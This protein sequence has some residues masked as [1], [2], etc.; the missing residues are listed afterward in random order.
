MIKKSHVLVFLFAFAIS[1]CATP[2]FGDAAI[3]ESAIFATKTKTTKS[4]FKR[5]LSKCR[6]VSNRLTQSRGVPQIRDVKTIESDDPADFLGSPIY[7]ENRIN[8]LRSI[9]NKK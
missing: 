1:M 3:L 9:L 8:R 5:S 7:Y 4:R 2:L 6:G